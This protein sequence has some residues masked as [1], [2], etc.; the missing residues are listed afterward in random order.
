M[1]LCGFPCSATKCFICPLKRAISLFSLSETI[2]GHIFCHSQD[3]VDYVNN[4]LVKFLWA[5]HHSVL[6]VQIPL[7]PVGVASTY[8]RPAFSLLNRTAQILRGPNGT[9]RKMGAMNCDTPKGL[10]CQKDTDTCAF[11]RHNHSPVMRKAGE[12]VASQRHWR[13]WE[14]DVATGVGEHD[15]T[16]CQSFS[17]PK[18]GCLTP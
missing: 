12:T 5:N 14:R 16:H 13:G 17:A 9:R 2:K 7:Q 6:Q 4:C 10:V 1:K 11:W 18:P 3:R 15:C 8:R